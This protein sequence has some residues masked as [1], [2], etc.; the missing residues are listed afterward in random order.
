MGTVTVACCYPLDILPHSSSP[1]T[2]TTMDRG[3]VKGVRPPSSPQ[4]DNASVRMNTGVKRIEAFARA[5]RGKKGHAILA[6][7]AVSIYL[8]NWVYSMQESTTYAYS[9]WATG[10]FQSHSTGLATLNIATSVISSVSVPFLGKFSDV[11][12]RPYI[13]VIAL[14]F[15][16]VGFV[17]IA[18]APTLAAYVLGSVF[19]AVGGAAIGLLN[20]VLTADLVPLQWRGAAQGLLSTPYLA[21]VWYTSKIA[22][23]LG[24]AQNW[25]WGFGMYAIIMPCVMGPALIMIIWGE[26]KARKLGYAQ[27]SQPDAT[28][29]SSGEDMKENDE[30]DLEERSTVGASATPSPSC[31]SAFRVAAAMDEEGHQCLSRA[32]RL[33]PDPPRFRLDPSPP[34]LL[35]PG[36]CRQWIQESVS[37]CDV[38]RWLTLP[39]RILWL[40]GGVGK[41][42]DSSDP[43]TQEPYLHHRH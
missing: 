31:R 41:V 10:S 16:V 29:R 5:T 40:R 43:A 34:A 33:W 14:V 19:V 32:G 21:T 37:D 13:Y 23:Q 7:I 28:A 25:R 3:E 11:F 15:Y 17:I 1:S 38:C 30:T 9:V 42:S 4:D 27:E 24:T 18:F 6:A 35:P 36:G 12:G 20:A 26:R 8:C 22:E 2:R 39:S